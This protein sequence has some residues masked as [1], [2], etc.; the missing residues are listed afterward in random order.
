MARHKDL[1]HLKDWNLCKLFPVLPDIIGKVV[2]H[3]VWDTNVK[4][5]G[6]SLQM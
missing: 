4:D 6:F 5:T 3:R 1:K 2:R